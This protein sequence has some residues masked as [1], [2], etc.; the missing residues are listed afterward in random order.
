MISAI[1]VLIGIQARSTSK[2]FPKK[3]FEKIGQ[4]RVIDHVIEKA[5]SAANHISRHNKLN[6]SAK[7]A[8]LIPVADK[9]FY[10]DFY[11]PNCLIFEGPE[12]D[13][14][15]R[16]VIA[17]KG[18]DADFVVRLTSD[19]PLML[20]YLISK[21]VNVAVF[22]NYDYVSN[23]E[24]SCRTIADGFDCEILSKRA[25]DWLDENA[26]GLDREH[27]TTLIRRDRPKDLKQAMIMSKLDTSAMKMSVDTETDL[28]TIRTYYHE[29]EHKK[30]LAEKIF[31]AKNIY[32]V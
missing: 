22:E 14:L 16:Y 13:V 25:L 1:R 9:V 3:I 2:R 26:K 7:A 18:Y 29:S 24:E 32:W 17:A 5:I 28:T 11:Y 10:S 20:D 21:H 27:V 30:E 4:R 31:G 15:S 6:L 19:C 23:V 8:L 12:N